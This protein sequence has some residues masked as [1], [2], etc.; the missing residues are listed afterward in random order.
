MEKKKIP[1]V[2]LFLS[3]ALTL[4]LL[5]FGGYLL[6]RS[7]TN[8]AHQVQIPSGGKTV[9]EMMGLDE[10]NAEAPIYYN[11]KWYMKNE[12]IDAY[13]LMG[14][15]RQGIAES[16]NS[17]IGGGQADFLMLLILDR[18]QEQYS[19][20]QINRDT[21]TKVEILGVQGDVVGT[22]TQQIALAHGYGTGMEDSCENT[23]RAVSNLLYGVEIEGYAAIQMDAL[24]IL[25]D[26]IGGVTLTIQDD[27][28]TIDPTLVKGERMTLKG[29]Q[30]M[31]YVRSRHH[32]ADDSNLS[33]M[34]RHRTYL[35]AFAQQAQTKAVEEPQLALALYDEIL[36]Y[37]VTNVNAKTVSQ[38]MDKCYTYKNQGI[39]TAVGEAKMGEEYIEYYLD[40]NRLIE[41]ILKLFYLEKNIGG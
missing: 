7:V 24:P 11:G 27:F 16:V 12:E 30:A 21:M 35:S 17:Y 36:P 3:V 15:D 34:E 4:G 28:S 20:F 31:N 33:R 1:A 5:A 2:L 26:R 19:I 8:Q 14:I 38:I 37:M 29:E 10:E 41:D 9:E 22:E 23:V 18:K 6:E 40:E 32:I 39:V 25:N 13:L